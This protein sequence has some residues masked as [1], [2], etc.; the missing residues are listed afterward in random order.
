M[1]GSSE[2]RC[3]VAS[4]CRRRQFGCDVRPG[5]TLE[6]DSEWKAIRF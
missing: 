5:E 6:L 1:S 3:Q 2:E 4:E